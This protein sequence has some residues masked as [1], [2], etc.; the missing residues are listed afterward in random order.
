MKSQQQSS[1]ILTPEEFVVRFLRELKMDLFH[2][3]CTN[4][5]C[6]GW[7]PRQDAEDEKT[8]EKAK[9]DLLDWYNAR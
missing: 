9:K 7:H 6:D 2:S 3:C 8:L 1:N 4:E 5:Y